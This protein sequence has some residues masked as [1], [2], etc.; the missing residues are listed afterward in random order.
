MK[1]IYQISIL[2]LWIINIQQISYAGG[3]TSKPQAE[4]QSAEL[5]QLPQSDIHAQAE[6]KVI[7]TKKTNRRVLAAA[8]LLRRLQEGH[9]ETVQAFQENPNLHNIVSQTLR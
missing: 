4:K 9:P 6:K 5:V 8:E 7:V 3:C 1:K 2:T